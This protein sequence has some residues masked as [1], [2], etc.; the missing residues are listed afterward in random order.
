[1]IPIRTRGILARFAAAFEGKT[2]A[3]NIAISV[4]DLHVKR[5]NNHI[6]RGITCNIPA[7]QCTGILGPNGSGKTTFT[8]AVT[9]QTFMTSGEVTV[10]GETIGQTDIRG[11]RQRIGVVNPTT[12]G[13][14]IHVNG[15]VVDADLSAHDAVCTGFFG[16]IGL[17]QVPTDE[18][19][20]RADTML[21]RVGL[22]HRKQLRFALLSTGEQRRCLIAR[23]MAIEPELL[24]LDEPT[25]GMDV[26]GREQVLATVHEILQQPDPP[27]VLFI[28]HHVEELPPSTK[29]VLLIKDGQILQRGAP[30]Q[31]IT[32]ELLSEMFGCK[33]FVKKLHGR[34]W[35]EVLPETW[36]DLLKAPASGTSGRQ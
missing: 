23:A 27:T 4:K 11:L 6:L 32:P 34:Y 20:A 36:L 15:A 29:Q 24:V 16:S 33:V 9:A 25:A 3:D 10:L 14:G 5:G 17:Y 35:L 2:L 30:E 28:T 18:Q 8:R 26:A 31:V 12:D 21:E 7:G 19:H 1:M 13:A 22:G